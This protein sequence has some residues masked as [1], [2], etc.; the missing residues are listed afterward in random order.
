MKTK[1]LSK[2][3]S[4]FRKKFI[5]EHYYNKTE[6]ILFDKAIRNSCLTYSFI[7]KSVKNGVKYPFMT[8]IE[9][10]RVSRAMMNLGTVM[11]AAAKGFSFFTEYLKLSEVK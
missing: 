8:D 7:Y 5:A 10:N 1:Q 3:E 4:K 2:G 9:L 6:Q 11:K